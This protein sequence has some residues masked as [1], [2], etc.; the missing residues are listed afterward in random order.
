MTCFKIILSTTQNGTFLAFRKFQLFNLFCFEE[1]ACCKA[2]FLSC[3]EQRQVAYKWQVLFNS[4]LVTHSLD[5]LPP[6]YL[7]LCLSRF[8]STPYLLSSPISEF[9]HP[10]ILFIPEIYAPSEKSI[11]FIS[12]RYPINLL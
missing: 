10:H 9:L 7:S 1:S 8:L 3:S 5:L 11:Y 4:D 12:I 2:H 6:P